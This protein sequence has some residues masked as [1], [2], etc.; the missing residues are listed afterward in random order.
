MT[1]SMIFSDRFKGQVAIVTGGADGL[2]KAIAQRLGAEGASI[3]LFDRNAVL[4]EQTAQNLAALNIP[5]RFYSVDISQEEQVKQAVEQT[6][7][8]FGKI[9][10]VV[11]SAGIVGPTSTNITSYATADFEKLL[12]VNLFG[13]F[14]IT[15]YTVSH[16]ASQ[17]YG[18]ILLIASIAGKEGNPGMV[19]YSVSK[20]GVIGLVKAIAKEYATAGITV[21]GLAPAVI[22]TAMNA[23]TAPEQRAYMTAKIPMGRLGEP[24]EVAAM[25]CFIVSPENSF[26]TGFIY[27]ISGGRAT[28]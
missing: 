28:Y 6:V 1:N 16:M 14:L 12:A 23:D 21:N 9:D 3:A 27:D 5:V 24:D 4:L 7:A 20:A 13:S 17:N 19:G 10:V 22:K 15:K 25:A 18:R 2:G 11:H 26:S 8:D